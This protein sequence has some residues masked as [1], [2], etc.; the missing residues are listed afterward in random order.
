MG[1]MILT[2]HIMEVQKIIKLK[3]CFSGIKIESGAY[4]YIVGP[5]D[6]N[7]IV[8]ETVAHINVMRHE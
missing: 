7:R 5:E 2:A 1:L 4:D 3:C 6:G 8:D